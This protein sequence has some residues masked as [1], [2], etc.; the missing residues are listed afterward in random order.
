VPTY[1]A[2]DRFFRD[3]TRLT[4]SQRDAF[5]RVRKQFVEDLVAGAEFRPSLRVKGLQ[6]RGRVMEMTWADDGRATWMRGRERKPG[7]THIT[8]RR[9][10]TRR[11][12]KDP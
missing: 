11:I 2:T 7:Q 4:R 8:W 6:R 10:G 12:L 3:L 1:D 9:I 5:D